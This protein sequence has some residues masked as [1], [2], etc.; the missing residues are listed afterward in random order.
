MSELAI[1]EALLGFSIGGL[2]AIVIYLVWAFHK[3][4]IR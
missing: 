3:V 2:I 1:V 4:R